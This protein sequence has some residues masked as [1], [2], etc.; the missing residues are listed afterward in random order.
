MYNLALKNI[1]KL[2]L[3]NK[4][5]IIN[6]DAYE[7]LKKIEEKFDFVF[8]DA[9]KGQYKKYFD[10]S[11]NLLNYGGVIISDNILFNGYVVENINY[12]KRK[13]TIVKRLIEYNNYLSNLRGYNTVFLPIDDGIAITYMEE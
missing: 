1:K 5:N 8:I 6:S 9:A 11:K 10:I 4:I 13:K 2:G 7:Y 3:E 12:P